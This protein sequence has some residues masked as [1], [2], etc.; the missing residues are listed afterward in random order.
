M[1]MHEAPHRPTAQELE[2]AE[3]LGL[4]KDDRFKEFTLQAAGKKFSDGNYDDAIAM[5]KTLVF[6]WPDDARFYEAF[7][8]V[9]QAQGKLKEARACFEVAYDLDDAALRANLNLGEMKWRIDKD[10]EGAA[11]HLAK[12]VEIDPD[13]PF[14]RRAK[15]TLKR[16]A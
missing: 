16:V 10:K 4:E 3:K 13:G 7:A 11:K 6:M 2:H 12:V 5:L 9:Y 15:L 8:A 14:G 1:S